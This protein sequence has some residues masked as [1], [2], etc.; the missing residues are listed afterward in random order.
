MYPFESLG[1]TEGKKSVRVYRPALC[2]NGGDEWM[3]ARSIAKVP[4]FTLLP[5]YKL[6]RDAVIGSVIISIWLATQRDEDVQ[7]AH[8]TH[9]NALELRLT[10]L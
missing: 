6:K 3:R 1:R 5:F 2:S 7:L 4:S 10:L 8:N 9:C